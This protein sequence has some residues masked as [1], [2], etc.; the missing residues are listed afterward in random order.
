MLLKI[1][2]TNI[3]AYTKAGTGDILGIAT[4]HI[5][6]VAGISMTGK[7]GLGVIRNT[8]KSA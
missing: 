3:T 2:A 8:G 4:H 1:P 5:T 7:T 6:T